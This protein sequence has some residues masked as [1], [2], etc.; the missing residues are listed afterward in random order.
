MIKLKNKYLTAKI[1]EKGAQIASIKDGDTELMWQKDPEIWN[2]YGPVLF[3]ICG[4]LKDN[5]FTH[6]GETYELCKHGFAKETEFDVKLLSKSSVTLSMTSNEETKKSY[7]FDFELEVTFTLLKKQMLVTYSV[8]NTGKETM[9]F[10]IGSH[11]GYI[12]EGSVEDY[13]IIFPKKETLDSVIIKDGILS[14]ETTPIIK[15]TKV[16]PIYEEYFEHDSVV[17]TDMV[18][19]K[20]V[21]RNRKTGKRI[22]VS[23]PGCDYFVIWH[24]VGAEYICLE[25]WTGIP[26]YA[27]C[28]GELSEK[29]GIMALKK[30]RK[31]RKTHK[32]SILPQY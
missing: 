31:Y 13:D 27:D 18:S 9:Y 20:A 11:E 22:G 23:F 2:N 32:I 6:N 21:L 8:K 19:R 30:G 3:P 24:K 1:Q 28:S 17:F 29:D 4:G 12:C 5:K 7:P 14:D 15:S 10:S 25:P 16:L 26:D